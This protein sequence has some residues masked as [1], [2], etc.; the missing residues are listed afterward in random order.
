MYDFV[1][2]EELYWSTIPGADDFVWFTIPD[3]TLERKTDRKLVTNDFKLSRW[4]IH[5]EL[6]TFD[7]QF[8]GQAFGAKASF[9]MKSHIQLLTDPNDRRPYDTAIT[10]TFEIV[11]NDLMNEWMAELLQSLDEMRSAKKSQVYVKRA[12][13][14]CQD[15]NKPCT[16][17]ELCRIGP[18]R[19]MLIPTWEHGDPMEYVWENENA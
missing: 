14:T 11:E 8:L 18:T 3:L 19:E 7:R 2:V 1:A 15:F 5:A 4:D 16:F 9:M 17:I 13:R 12:P 10:R 6:N